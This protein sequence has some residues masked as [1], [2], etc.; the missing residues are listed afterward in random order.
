[1]CQTTEYFIYGLTKSGKVFR[2][3]D[4]AERLTGVISCFRPEA[5]GQNAYLQ[6][7]P[8]VKP[9]LLGSIKCAI[10]DSRLRDIEPLAFDFVMNFAKDNDLV[11]TEMC[12]L[13]D[14]ENK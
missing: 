6:Y 5:T 11:V 1:M 12:T 3:S 2:P 10:L 14:Y 4:W 8:Y 9:T 7:S 13:S